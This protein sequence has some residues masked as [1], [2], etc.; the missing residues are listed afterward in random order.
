MLLNVAEDTQLL[1]TQLLL[2]KT[3]KSDQELVSENR[4]FKFCVRN[5][6]NLVIYKVQQ[7]PAHHIPIWSSRTNQEFPFGPYELKVERD[8][9]LRLYDGN[10]K[11]IWENKVKGKG[12]GKASAKMENDGNFVVYDCENIALWCTKTDGGNVAREEY[13]GVGHSLV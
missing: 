11:C 2:F 6:G 13:Q 8:N 9:Q 10:G 4:R 12:I 3:L 7:L 5:D 1:K